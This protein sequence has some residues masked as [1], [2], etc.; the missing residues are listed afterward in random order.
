MQEYTY[1][2]DKELNHGL[3]KDVLGMPKWWLGTVGFLFLVWITGLGAYGWELNQG[4]GVLGVNRPVY[5]GFLITN[6]VK[7]A[8]VET[9][10]TAIFGAVKQ[11]I[12]PNIMAISTL[13]LGVSVVFVT[14]SWLIGR[15]GQ[16]DKA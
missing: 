4:V 13:M 9:L 6:F 3:L 5:W 16:P 11:G 12:K 7:G 14:L 8:G 1:S 15:S 10:P 2:T